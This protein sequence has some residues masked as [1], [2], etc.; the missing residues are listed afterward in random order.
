MPEIKHTFQGGKMNKDLDERLVR[1]GEYRN[2]MNIQVR[3]T[4]ASSSSDGDNVGEGDAGTVQNLKGN[5]MIGEAYFAPW[6]ADETNVVDPITR[7][8]YPRCVANIADE[9][10]DKAYFF[11]ASSLHPPSLKSSVVATCTLIAL[12][13]SPLRTILSSR[14]LFIFPP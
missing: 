7:S 9:K 10:N 2:A 13:Y 3:S 14:S 1:N 12:E 8:Q 6:M 11:F 5:A 4:D